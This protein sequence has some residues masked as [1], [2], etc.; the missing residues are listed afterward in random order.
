MYIHIYIFSIHVY[1]YSIYIYIYRYSTQ[2]AHEHLSEDMP[3]SLYE[4]TAVEEEVTF[5]DMHAHLQVIE[6]PCQHL[7]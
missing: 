1:I 3:V 5:S 6:I 4:V 7:I 2:H